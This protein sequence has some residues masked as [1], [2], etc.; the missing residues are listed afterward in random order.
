MLQAQRRQRFACS[1]HHRAPPPKS[2]GVLETDP[3]ATSRASEGKERQDLPG[4]QRRNSK[5]YVM[6]NSPVST[7][8]WWLRHSM[9]G[10]TPEDLQA[11]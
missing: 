3:T 2:T 6:L 10:S 5:G 9:K 11:P 8:M 4:A 7:T 1:P